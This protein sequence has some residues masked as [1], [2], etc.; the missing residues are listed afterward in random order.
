MQF[1]QK[2]PIKTVHFG[3]E[4]YPDDK[5]APHDATRQQ[6]FIERHKTSEDWTDGM[7]VGAL[8][9]YI[10]CEYLALSTPINRYYK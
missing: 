4:D 5:A 2:T 8:S 7:A 3:A 6:R 9:S 1:P 10:L